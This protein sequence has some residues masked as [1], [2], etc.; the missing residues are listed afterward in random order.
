[1]TAYLPG[2]S[3]YRVLALAA[4][5]GLVPSVWLEADERDEELAKLRQELQQTQQ[6]L[7]K[8]RDRV[9]ELEEQVAAMGGT[10]G[11]TGDVP[12]PMAGQEEGL[13]PWTYNMRRSPM[14]VL[15]PG[16]ATIP[17]HDFYG[18]FTHVSRE[19]MNNKMGSGQQTEPFHNLLGLEDNVRIGML[20][21]YGLTDRWDVWVQRTNGRTMLKDWSGD[22]ASFDYW[23]VMTKYHLLDEYEQGVDLSVY[24]GITYMMEDNEAGNTSVNAGLTVERSFLSDRVRLSTGVLYASLSAYEETTVSDP[25]NDVAMTKQ[26]PGELPSPYLSSGDDYTLSIPV[27]LSL[28]LTNHWQLFTEGIFP[29]AGY[30]TGK[31]PTL[32]FGGR[33]VTNTH[34][35]AL[36]FMN[37]ANNSFNSLLTGGYRR[38]RIDQFGFSISIYY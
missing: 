13:Q 25:D 5:L 22:S 34:E 24:G 7:E 12:D 27:G 23:D 20:L 11:E 38:D 32:A 10:P 9:Q 36:F 30:D 37:S 29:V 18:R 2:T 21:G 28:A 1:M 19:S 26:M 17:K 6:K 16:A 35:F 14:H 15:F 31:G 8:A 4:L 33:Y 3:L